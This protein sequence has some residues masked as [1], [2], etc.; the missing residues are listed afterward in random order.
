VVRVVVTVVDGNNAP[1]TLTG[2]TITWKL[3]RT[4]AGASL[5]SLSTASGIAISE[6]TAAPG[7]FVVT[8]PASSTTGYSGPYYHEARVTLAS[9]PE[10]V[11]YGKVT[12]LPSLG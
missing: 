12:I 9:V 7:E 10:V 1:V 8:I 5:V 3:A 6:Q 11:V 4:A 2:G